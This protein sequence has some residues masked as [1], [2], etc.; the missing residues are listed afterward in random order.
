MVLSKI[1]KILWKSISILSMITFL[2]VWISEGFIFGKAYMF[3][4]TGVLGAYFGF[5][6][7]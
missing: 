6:K 5:K 4:I 2:W 1:I 7:K 3:L